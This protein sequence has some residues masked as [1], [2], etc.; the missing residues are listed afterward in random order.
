MLTG[1]I[2]EGMQD[3]SEAKGVTATSAVGIAQGG[4]Q[5]HPCSSRDAALRTPLANSRWANPPPRAALRR[6]LEPER[7]GR[8]RKE[9]YSDQTFFTTPTRCP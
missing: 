2:E 9:T 1:L 7:S 6:G 3:G 5:D 4:N 8:T